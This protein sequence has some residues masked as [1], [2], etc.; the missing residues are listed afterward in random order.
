MG[1]RT[2]EEEEEDAAAEEFE[3][4]LNVLREKAARLVSKSS[5]SSRRYE[6][7]VAALDWIGF[8]QRMRGL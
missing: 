4:A 5:L 7:G 2:Y 8:T 6:E 3:A 1:Y